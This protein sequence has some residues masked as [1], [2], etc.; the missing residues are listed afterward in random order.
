MWVN[1]DRMFV[2]WVNDVKKKKAIV[3]PMTLSPCAL[4]ANYDLGRLRII[5]LHACRFV[6]RLCSCQISNVS[7]NAEWKDKLG[8][9]NAAYFPIQKKL[10]NEKSLGQILS[11][12]ARFCW[13]AIYYCSCIVCFDYKN[14]IAEASDMSLDISHVCFSAR[15]PS[16]LEQQRLA[17]IGMLG[18]CFIICW[19]IKVTATWC[20]DTPEKAERKMSVLRDSV[21]HVPVD[22]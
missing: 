12:Q 5:C 15:C 19:H 7:P 2:F 6:V 13:N 20:L 8:N 21:C 10:K 3:L 9:V 4:S 1:D 11:H 17:Y 18:I 22:S 16:A 14:G